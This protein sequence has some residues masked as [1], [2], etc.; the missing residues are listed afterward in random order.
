MILLYRSPTG[1]FTAIRGTKRQ[2]SHVYL[3]VL[4]PSRP[5]Q[6]LTTFANKKKQFGFQN[7]HFSKEKPSL[8]NETFTFKKSE[9]TPALLQLPPAPPARY[10]SSSPLSCRLAGLRSVGG[11]PPVGHAV[12]VDVVEGQHSRDLG[13]EP[14]CWTCNLRFATTGSP[15]ATGRSAPTPPSPPRVPPPQVVG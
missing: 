2:D 14:T 10:H 12:S 6:A 1:L 7:F 5:Y 11:E 4:S 8:L 3:R 13:W 15:P 9:T